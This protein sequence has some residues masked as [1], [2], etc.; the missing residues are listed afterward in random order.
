M[1][2][3]FSS[4][5]TPVRAACSGG[6][7]RSEDPLDISIKLSADQDEER[8]YLH[9]ELS[10]DK[11]RGERGG[12]RALAIEYRDGNWKWNLLESEKLKSLEEYL[13]AHPAASTQK[14]ANDCPELGSHS[15]I[16]KLLAKL[17]NRP[18]EATP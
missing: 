9:C 3:V 4:F 10:Y 5:T 2:C 16:A 12:F 11:V 6:H 17:K 1:G 13:C 15:T 18:S 14:I 8:D 7:S